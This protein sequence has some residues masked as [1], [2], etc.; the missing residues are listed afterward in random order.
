MASIYLFVIPNY[1][2]SLMN[3]KRE[4]I[5]ELT[6]T[7][8]SVLQKLDLMVNDDFDI[9][10]AQRE[11][12]IIIGDMRYGDELKDYFW[13]TDTT[14]RMVM[15]PYRPSMIGMDLTD[16]RDP[17]GKNFF[18][19][20]VNIVRT[21]GDG[22]VDY[23]WQWKDDSLTVVPKLSYVKAFQ[24]WGWIVGTG[25]YIEDVNKEISNLT[26]KVVWISVL[27]TL[28]I[29]AIIIYLARRNYVAEA[30]RQKAQER[31]RDSMQRYKK[32]V[33]ASTDGVLMII[34]NEIVYCNPYLLNLLEYTQEEFDKHDDQFY[35]TLGSFTQFDLKENQGLAETKQ[36]EIS[37]EQKIKKK[38]GV[39]IDV[40]VNRSNFELEG[41]QGFIFAVKDVSKH[42]DVER[43]LDL[44]M[45]KFKSIAGLMNLGIFRCTLGR[46]SR[47]VEINSKALEL[48]GY[49]S[50]YELKDTQVQDLIDIAN[51]KKEV[52]R[53][54]N[55]G[56]HVKDRL[57]RLKRA[58]GTV[59]SALVS[60][61]P[62]HD[63]H[64]KTVF[65]D[66]IIVDAYDHLCHD[67]GFDKST[68]SL[69]L[70]ANILLHPI[71]D[72]L[73]PAPQCEM[74]ATVEVA[75]KLMTS[76][77]SDIIIVMSDKSSIVGLVTH[78]D[79]SRRV[80]ALGRSL[81]VPVSEIMSAPVLAVNDDDMVM[82]AFNLMVQHKISYVVVKSKENAKSSYISLIRLSELRKDTPE[83]MINAI[84]KAGS[85][86]EIAEN[87]EHLPQLVKTL[88]ETGTGVATSGKLISKISDTIT[89]KLITVAIDELGQPPAPFAFL[90]LGS[91]GRREQTLATD[92]D[93]AI[94]YQVDS[95]HVEVECRN[96]F[97][98]L[99]NRVC[100]SLNRV[101]YPLCK[102][103]VMAMN[104]E[105]CMEINEW[106]KSISAWVNTPNPQEILNTSIF[107]DFRP[108]YGDFELANVLQNF[109]FK[110][111]KEKNV[112]FFNLAKSI[113]ELKVP[114][115]DGPSLATNNLDVKLPILAIT[116]IARLWSLKFGIGERN[117]SERFFA[118]QSA[119]V[120]NAN[121][122]ED[123]EQALRYLM[124]LRIKNQ[125][126]QIEA[127]KTPTN[128]IHSKD[129]AGI[130]RIML[131]KVVS[132]ITDHQNRLGLDFR[133]T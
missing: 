45:E 68:S 33:E 130:D 9:K 124:M 117:T 5:S 110:M 114:S 13:I 101:G 54:I 85:I 4:T 69:H 28:I 36:Q 77:K 35:E 88:V 51:E 105:W 67:V 60:L 38:N 96:Y 122:R 120:I 99:G 56:I 37:S 70:S 12:V 73:L 62:V 93:N 116:S 17:K 32:L 118:L 44:S 86:Y 46:Q 21:N 125:L 121:L 61:F 59:L 6:N 58:D 127:G 97:L 132:T 41:K 71:K 94:I 55:E 107:F 26:Q 64:G 27:I 31:L 48:L 129:I 81:S 75:S 18:V 14:P 20:I 74:D 91:E 49:N 39:S 52:I 24:P 112:Y 95:S 29:S 84:Q 115:I 102:G 1:R 34:E 57:L 16:Y 8:W 119:G 19:D 98:E 89:D 100:K 87:M 76:T 25:I 111:L 109:C 42:K 104:K 72:Y 78:S 2:E 66:G 63:A 7:A 22:F 65:F 11:A 90:T 106:K 123:F 47:F 30:E 82:D 79:I 23:K 126:S 80:V 113:I 43:E 53:V 83:F 133:L 50:E 108:V 15:H 128:E 131:K 10:Q 3:G 40:I 92:Q 103:G